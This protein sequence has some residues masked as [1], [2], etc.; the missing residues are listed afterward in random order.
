VRLLTL[1]AGCF[2]L[3]A[4]AGARAQGDGARNYQLVPD[5]ARSFTIFGIYARGNQAGD[6]SAIVQGATVDAYL[7]VLQYSQAVSLAGNQVQ[8]FAQLPFGETRGTAHLANGTPVSSSSSGLGDLQLGAMFGLVGSPALKDR[9]YA[10]YRP[11]FALGALVK[12]FLPTGEYD[13]GKSINLGANR[14]ALQLGTPLVRYVGDSFSDPALMSFELTPSITFF[15]NNNAPHDAGTRSQDPLGKLEGHVTRN[16]GRRLWV[17]ADAF[18]SYGGETVTDQV[19]DNNAQRYLGLGATAGYA[20]SDGLSSTLT[21]G[22]VVKRNEGGLD[23]R[24]VRAD[25]IFSF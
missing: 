24:A 4:A 10:G 14:W 19:R 13:F 17:S 1:C 11:G 21:Y 5:G 18:Y 6:P 25:L 7:G 16:L 23:L 3:L 20:L 12:V 15:T 22:K 2:L 9:D 8:L